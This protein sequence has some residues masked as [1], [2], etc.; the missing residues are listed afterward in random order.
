MK[1]IGWTN[2]RWA[3]KHIDKQREGLTGRQASRQIDGRTVGE[4]ERQ[5]DRQLE[6]QTSELTVRSTNLR[7]TIQKDSNLQTSRQAWK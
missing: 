4:T 7:S 5:A 2:I 3:N 1:K 6:R